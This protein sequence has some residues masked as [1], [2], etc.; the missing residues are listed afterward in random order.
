MLAFVEHDGLSRLFTW[1]K[2]ESQAASILL[3]RFET[4]LHTLLCRF[5]ALS[6]VITPPLNLFFSVVIICV[7][8][9][10]CVIHVVVGCCHL[11]S[12]SFSVVCSVCLCLSSVMFLVSNFISVGFW[13]RAKWLTCF[14][15]TLPLPCWSPCL[16]LS[17][18]LCSRR[19]ACLR[20]RSR[21]LV[22][23]FL[24]MPLLCS[25][26]VRRV[27]YL[28]WL[29]RLLASCF[30]PFPLFHLL[31]R[32]AALQFLLFPFAS[33]AVVPFLLHAAFLVFSFW[34]RLLF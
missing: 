10:S 33:P 2:P 8:F 27:C 24:S 14:W 12:S 13:L 31:L 21:V 15:C 18:R 32:L 22:R 16:R 29:R 1:T 34:F 28:L 5:L 6:D 7:W 20:F 3:F 4:S 11:S 25:D 23:R 19:V 30:F 26:L 9:V 17:R